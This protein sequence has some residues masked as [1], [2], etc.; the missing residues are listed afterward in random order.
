M[1][2]RD[3]ARRAVLESAVL[4]VL[5]EAYDETRVA[6]RSGM[7]E[8]DRLKITADDGTDLGQVYVTSP[9]GGG[10]YI[11]DFSAL[12]LWVEKHCP[13]YLVT[14]TTVSTT[15]RDRLLRAGGEWLD[16]ATGEVLTP[17]GMGTKPRP[18]GSLTVKP[19]EAATDVARRLLG[20]IQ[21][22]VEA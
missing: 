11:Y 22:A 2:D 21:Q 13:E 20:V 12:M 5:S 6:L 18:T 15:F 1:P 9:K 4:D 8:G 17:D 7:Q 3:L 14:T 19:T 10:A 16:E